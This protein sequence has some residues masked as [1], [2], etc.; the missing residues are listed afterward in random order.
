LA[1]RPQLV[2]AL[3]Y[4]REGDVLVAWRLDRLGRSLQHLVTRITDLQVRGIGFR[5]LTEYIDTAT[6]TG[7][8]MLHLFGAFAQFE[9]D[10]L[11]ERTHAGLAAA[12]ARGRSGGR[13]PLMTPKRLQLARQMHE[14]G[15]STVEQMAETLGVSRNDSPSPS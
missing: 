4:L 11:A 5:S 3:A 12:R 15:D 1:E 8:L 7:T 10:L 14:Q 2:A 13:K 6:P 9:R